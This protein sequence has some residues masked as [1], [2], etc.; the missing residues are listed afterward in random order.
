[1]GT[2][3][4]T[5]TERIRRL[6]K[7][8]RELLKEKTTNLTEAT[9]ILSNPSVIKLLKKRGIIISGEGGVWLWQSD[10]ELTEE[11]ADDLWLKANALKGKKNEMKKFPYV[12]KK[13]ID[14]SEDGLIDH[15]V[16]SIDRNSIESFSR[17]FTELT[18]ILLECKEDLHNMKAYAFD[19][20]QAIKDIKLRINNFEQ[21]Q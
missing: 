16:K 2:L 19:I 18:S 8:R 20:K 17:I 7:I 12:P 5:S 1:M 21:Q 13:E 14:D 6:K 3:L 11:F 4:L 10:V 9:R 15:S